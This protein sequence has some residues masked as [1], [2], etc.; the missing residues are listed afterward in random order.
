[1]AAGEGIMGMSSREQE[2]GFGGAITLGAMLALGAYLR[3]SGLLGRGLVEW[4]E[5]HYLMEAK[6]LHSAYAQFFN[7]LGA[8][9]KGDPQHL[10]ALLDGWPI[11]SAKPGHAFLIFLLAVIVGM[12]DYVGS[13]LN[14]GLG[15]ATVFLVY[16]VG[17]SFWGRT[18]G[19]FSA[20]V[21]A[22]SG[23][24]RREDE[25]EV[26]MGRRG[27][28]RLLLDSEL[29]LVFCGTPFDTGQTCVGVL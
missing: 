6:F 28:F 9:Q 18:V 20:S 29:P 10:M 2:F 27:R 26:P 4:D 14:A 21:L 3:F 24:G 11:V 5:A 19:L 22:A 12:K 23:L 16:Q 17:R 13:L 1:M 25:P 15:I 8:L 7:L